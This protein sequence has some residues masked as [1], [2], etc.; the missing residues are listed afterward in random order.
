M[1]MPLINAIRNYLQ[2]DGAVILPEMELLLFGLGILLIDFWIEQK[3]KYLNAGLALAGA[4]FSAFT[5]WRL[6]GA[7]AA[8]VACLEF[9]QSAII[10]SLFIKINKDLIDDRGLMILLSVKYLEIEKEQE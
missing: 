9:H 4:L 8:R 2:G 7:V 6:R 1:N 10:K 3:E 5:L